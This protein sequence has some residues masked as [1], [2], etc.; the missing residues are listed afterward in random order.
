MKNHPSL[1]HQIAKQTKC[2]IRS[3]GDCSIQHYAK[4]H[5]IYISDMSIGL[6]QNGTLLRALPSH[7]EIMEYHD[8]RYQVLQKIIG[9]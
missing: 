9:N 8:Q 5:Q 3:H 6:L 4:Y 1:L 7:F 2:K